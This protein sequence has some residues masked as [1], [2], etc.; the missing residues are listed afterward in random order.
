MET[1]NKHP[2]TGREGGPIKLDVAASWTKNYREKNP[3]QTISQFFGKHILENI[4]KQEGCLGIRFYYAQDNEGKKHLIIAGV[5]SDGSDQTNE[6]YCDDRGVAIKVAAPV[7]GSLPTHK[8]YEVGDQSSPCP[9]SPG[10]P[11]GI[12]AT[13]QK[14]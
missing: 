9:G 8:M 4:L 7:G 13:G 14:A 6:E 10:C 1:E 12:L 3:G 5:N 2:I 11:K